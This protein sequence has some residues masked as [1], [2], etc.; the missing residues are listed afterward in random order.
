MICGRKTSTLPT[1]AITP[2]QI[3]LLQQAVRQ[4]VADRGAERSR[5]R[6]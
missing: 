2:S 5:S 4:G 6:R 3:R 1:P